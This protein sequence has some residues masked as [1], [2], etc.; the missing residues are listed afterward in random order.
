MHV[1]LDAFYASVE[2]RD[3]A[4]LRGKPVIVCMFTR[5]GQS[6][7][8]A[9]ASYEARKLGVHSGMALFEAKSKAPDAIYVPADI[10][11]YKKASEEIMSF[12]HSQSKSFEQVSIDEAFL[13]V[14][15]APA[16]A[17]NI[18]DWMAEHGLSCSI[19]VGKNKLVSK[20][21]AKR[22]KPDGL[23]IVPPGSEKEFVAP[24]AVGEI[25]F[26][27]RKAEERLA[28]M[29]IERVSDLARLP[30]ARLVEEFGNSRGDYYY[31]ASRGEDNSP[32]NERGAKAQSGRIATLAQDTRD[33][34]TLLAELERLAKSAADKA[35]Q[36]FR[37]V[38]VYLV[39]SNRTYKSKQ[40]T[41][42]KST[43]NPAEALPAISRLLD[44]LMEE[45]TQN[46]RRAGVSFSGFGKT[47][48]ARP[49]PKTGK[50]KEALPQ[51][52]LSDY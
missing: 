27:G 7:A 17:K 49:S 36:Q 31:H 20:I 42:E 3:H 11:R 38:S 28:G 9:T 41:L 30:L 24:L 32:V 8:V 18:R 39:F 52:S 22:A 26:L 47:R 51:K 1:D 12:L 37:R 19:G 43:A 21:A 15:D 33:K 40:K 14:D 6:G 5:G 16:T 35:G 34:S 10:A 45:N 50:R 23:T 2:Q 48:P 4:E 44:T 29:N 13:E 25:P 46:V